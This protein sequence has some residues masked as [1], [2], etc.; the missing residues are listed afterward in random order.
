MGKLHY[1]GSVIDID[2]RTLAHLQIVIVNRLRKKEGFLM[3]WLNTLAIGDG[4]GS[5]W[6]DHTIPLRFDF[7][8]SRSPQI[9]PG[10]LATLDKSAASATGLLVTGED[11]HL[12]RCGRST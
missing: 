1:D 7:S 12:L 8:G 5:V 10:W 2:D 6:L 11:G 3:S 4:R 9:N